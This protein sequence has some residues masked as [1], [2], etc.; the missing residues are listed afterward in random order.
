MTYARVRAAFHQ[1]TIRAVRPGLIRTRKLLTYLGQ[2]DATCPAVQITG[3]NGKGSVA[4]LLSAVLT[5]AGYR[6]GCFTSPHLQ[7]E[8]ERITLNG[9]K[10]P[11][12]TFAAAG[13][14]LLPGLKVLQQAGTPATT[15]E[16]WTVLAA[17]I[18]RQEGI[19]LA[20][21]EVG[22]G[23]RLDA[24][25]VW[26]RV[27][28]SILTNVGLE[29]TRELG[30]TLS[31]IC[32]EKIA[33]A[34]K[35]VPLLSA[36]ARPGLRGLMRCQ[37][38]RKLFPLEFAGRN[39]SDAVKVKIWKRTPKGLQIDLILKQRDLT[40]NST[41]K[42][43]CGE[44]SFKIH[45]P[46]HG[47]FQ[48]LNA[49]LAVLAIKKLQQAGYEISG[50]DIRQGFKSAHWPGRMEMVG[51]KPKI[52]LDGA[53]NPAAVH[54]LIQ[55]WHLRSRKVY[56]V[57]GIVKEKDVSGMCREFAQAAKAVWTVA[58]PDPRALPAKELAKH[59]Q[60]FGVKAEP[61]RSF[62]S[63]LKKAVRAAGPRGTVLVAGSLYNIAP[64]RRALGRLKL[65]NTLPRNPRLSGRSN[66]T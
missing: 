18:F 8:R 54:A 63:A 24:T 46:W 4:A 47:E 39:S 6:V 2:P 53:H 65:L 11:K 55:E 23:G 45:I 27:I 35:G 38:R 36:E 22:M 25:S 40:C 5:Q 59:F 13:K 34:R 50:K 32:R 56:L 62:Q 16:A 15:F 51:R 41:H 30:N 58:P 14:R 49:A 28:L 37:A 44:N 9:K 12:R 1:L 64:A 7:D 60:A 3:T 43:Y 20:V 66:L 52:Y 48:V 61:Q 57:A 19:D 31:A 42:V 17:E 21:I 26:K 33:I 29:H 10:V